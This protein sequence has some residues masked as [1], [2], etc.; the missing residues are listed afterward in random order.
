MQRDEN[1]RQHKRDCVQDDVR[2]GTENLVPP[3][4]PPTIRR[5]SRKR[6]NLTLAWRSNVSFSLTVMQDE[7][8]GRWQR[9][10]QQA[11][12]EQD[13]DRMLELTR[14]IL[15]MLTDKTRRLQGARSSSATSRREVR[16]V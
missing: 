9:V 7:D 1:A 2:S 16:V 12:S 5:R 3:A 14:E 8:L 15:R 6:R 10:C 11:A 13:P 4:V